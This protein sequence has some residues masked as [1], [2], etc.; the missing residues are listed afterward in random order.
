MKLY[1]SIFLNNLSVIFVNKTLSNQLEDVGA[2]R[3]FKSL[4]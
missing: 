4:S 1:K 2:Y 3:L